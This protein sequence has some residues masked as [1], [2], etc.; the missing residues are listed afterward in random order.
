MEDFMIRKVGYVVLPKVRKLWYMPWKHEVVYD[1]MKI[2]KGKRWHDP[3]YGNGGGCFIN[4]T[5]SKRVAT[6]SNFT[7][8]V[9]FKI[10]LK[11]EYYEQ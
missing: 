6:F 8:A 3:S 2:T 10:R 11:A 5:E 1:V 9:A 7:T 4:F